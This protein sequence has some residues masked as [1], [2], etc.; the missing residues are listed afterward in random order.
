MYS[1]LLFE[2]SY[3][4]SFHLFLQACC[5]FFFFLTSCL[6]EVCEKYNFFLRHFE[7]SFALLLTDLLA[8]QRILVDVD[9]T[10]VPECPSSFYFRS[11][12][13]SNSFPHASWN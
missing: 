2:I 12:I 8:F 10:N 9:A 3:V 1:L 13:S 6:K 11:V 7:L 5:I 4:V